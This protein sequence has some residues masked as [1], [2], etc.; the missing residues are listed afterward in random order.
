MFSCKLW[1]STICINLPE[2]FTFIFLPF[3]NLTIAKDLASKTSKNAFPQTCLIDCLTTSEG[4]EV[5]YQLLTNPEALRYLPCHGPSSLRRCH[6]ACGAHLSHHLQSLRPWQRAEPTE[7]LGRWGRYGKIN[8]DSMTMSKWATKQSHTFRCFLA[9]F[10]LVWGCMSW[11]F[12]DVIAT[13]IQ[14]SAG[15]FREHRSA[16]CRPSFAGGS[17]R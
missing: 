13:K 11:I 17:W 6:E 5:M 10:S 1:R 3:G 9:F 16:P 4:W 2:R 12:I 14:P 15:T 8:D 7:T